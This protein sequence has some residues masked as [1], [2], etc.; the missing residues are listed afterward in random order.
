MEPR[1][2]GYLSDRDIQAHRAELFPNESD[3][4]MAEA[5]SVDLRLGSEYHLSSQREPG[6]LS[7]DK[8]HLVIPSGD[9]AVLMTKE[10]VCVPDDVIGFI[11]MRFTYKA[12]GLINV[13]GFHVDPGY[14]GR[15]LYAVYNAGP[16]DI[17]VSHEEKL[18]MIFFSGLNQP[19]EKPYSKPGHTELPGWAVANLTS[20]PNPTNIVSLAQSVRR[21][22]DR[23][24]LAL[25]TLA[26]VMVPVIILV[27]D[28]WVA[29]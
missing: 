21:L 4:I 26:I 27:V 20:G 10:T 29:R 25:S 9:F 28:R 6:R 12:K 13:S 14:E 15:L 5:A 22:E 16:K 17:F 3:E 18:F 11:T 7:A 1:F 2:Q 8:P 19:A 24:T 23:F